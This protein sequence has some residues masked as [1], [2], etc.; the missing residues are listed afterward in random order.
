MNRA[1]LAVQLLGFAACGWAWWRYVERPAQLHR[2]RQQLE[3]EL[4]ELERAQQHDRAAA[5]DLAAIN[6]FPYFN[7][8]GANA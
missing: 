6:T 2:R 5:R 4:R 7:P 8:N 3:R 1:L